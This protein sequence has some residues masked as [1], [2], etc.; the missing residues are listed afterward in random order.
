VTLIPHPVLVPR[1]KKQS[2]SIPLLSLRAFV[3][4]KKGETYVKSRRIRLAEHVE[5]MGKK[6]GVYRVLVGKHEGNR[7]LGRPRRR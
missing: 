3:A 7:P 2:R 6:R 1:S 5:G 4:C